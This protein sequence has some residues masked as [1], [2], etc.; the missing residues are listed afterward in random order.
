[1]KPQGASNILPIR[2]LNEFRRGVGLC[3]YRPDGLV[4]AARRLDDPQGSWQMPQVGTACGLGACSGAVLGDVPDGRNGQ[5]AALCG[6]TVCLK[7][8]AS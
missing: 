5:L 2:E 6:S 8:V 4:F 7:L 1:M 3:I